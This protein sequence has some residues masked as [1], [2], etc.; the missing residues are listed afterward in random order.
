MEID[1]L[2]GWVEAFCAGCRPSGHLSKPG[3][4]MLYIHV[5]LIH[6]QNTNIHC[7]FLDFDLNQSAPAVRLKRNPVDIWAMQV[8]EV[9]MQVREVILKLGMHGC[10]TMNEIGS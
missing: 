7:H 2:S 4:S 8:R 1:C 10:V 5:R 3:A 9:L 6:Y